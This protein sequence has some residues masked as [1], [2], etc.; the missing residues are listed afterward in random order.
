MNLSLFDLHCD[1]VCRM[2]ERGEGFEENNL[3]V[4][5]NRASVF[6]KY[7]QVMALFTSS[8]LSDSEGW[9]RSRELLSVLHGDSTTQS[10]K[11]RLCTTPS[12][13][14]TTADLLLSIEDARILE[15]NIDRV[16]ILYHDGI[17]ILTPLW[18]GETCIGGSHDTNVGLTPFGKAALKHAVKLGMLLDI[19]HASNTSAEEIFDICAA[20]DAPV[21]A[22]HSNAFE[23]CPVSRNLTREQTETILRSNGIIGINLCRPFLALDEKNADLDAVLRHI[24]YFCSI[25]A[26]N[27]LCLGCDMDGAPLPV[28]L[29][30]ISRL[31]ALAEHLQKHNYPDELIHAIFFENAYRFS[32]RYL[33]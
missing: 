15:N 16:D 17:R 25:G 21:I 5:L 19:S 23:I 4:S 29:C 31:P 24:E 27:A 26:Q 12:L 2:Y 22:S 1:T 9:L 14:Y 13:E 3:A 28:E 6:Q 32:V 18:R 11:A 30:D 33:H 10:G 8:R 7:V 20:N